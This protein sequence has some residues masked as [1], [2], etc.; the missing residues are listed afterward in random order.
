MRKNARCY[1]LFSSVS[2][3]I[4][5]S[6]TYLKLIVEHSHA[7]GT[8]NKIIGFHKTHHI[9]SG[10]FSTHSVAHITDSRI[11]SHLLRRLQW[12]HSRKLPGSFTLAVARPRS[13]PR[14]MGKQTKYM[15]PFEPSSG[16]YEP[17]GGFTVWHFDCFIYLTWKEIA[18]KWSKRSIRWKEWSMGDNVVQ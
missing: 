15:R 1:H 9:S 17:N 7:N 6:S 5:T 10:K 13:F 3:T 8:A 11:A 2:C 18:F 12:K 14:F 4:V 16:S